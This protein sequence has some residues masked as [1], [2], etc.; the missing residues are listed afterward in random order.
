MKACCAGC[1][2]EAEPG[3]FSL[4]WNA[5]ESGQGRARIGGSMNGVIVACAPQ[6]SVSASSRR[7]FC[8]SR[9]TVRSVTPSA[10]AISVS[11]MPAK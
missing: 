5:R 7:A 6:R 3:S 10:S 9:R 1:I 8:Q 4:T 11:V 2:A